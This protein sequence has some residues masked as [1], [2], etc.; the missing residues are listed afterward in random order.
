[1]DST[2]KAFSA[3]VMAR[4]SAGVAKCQTLALLSFH[5]IEE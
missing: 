4:G 5:F 2:E 3:M 1:M